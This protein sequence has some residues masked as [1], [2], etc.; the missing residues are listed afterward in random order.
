MKQIK[1]VVFDIDGT[2]LS[3]GKDKIEESAVNAIHKLKE[4][5]IKVLVAT[6]RSMGFIKDHVKEVLDCDYYV[7]INGHCVLDRNKEVIIRHTINPDSVNRML[8]LC[9]KL[10][11]PMGL[12]TAHQMVVLNDYDGFYKHYSQGFD[13]RHLLLDDTQNHDYFIK[14]DA[15]LSIFLITPFN[16]IEPYMKDFPEF[17]FIG[18]GPVSMDVFGSDIN[19]TL[20]IEEVL[21]LNQLT[22]DNVMTFGDGDN[23]IDMTLKAAIGISMGNATENMK[24]ISDFVTLNVDQGGIEHGL[25]HYNLI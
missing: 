25:K 12:K 21:E 9:K 19:K 5:G 23:D 13:V 10:N 24:A 1:M 11:I 4:N 7:T 15:P 6:G 2:L 18:A 17:Q 20:G 22:W 3:A 8:D 14:V 16:F